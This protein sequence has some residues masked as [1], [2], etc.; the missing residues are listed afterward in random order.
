ML[1]AYYPQRFRMLELSAGNRRLSV[2]VASWGV[3]TIVYL[4]DDWRPMGGGFRAATLRNPW[5]VEGFEPRVYHAAVKVEG[6]W[7]DRKM[8]GTGAVVVRSLR[9]G[10]RKTV[11]DAFVLACLDNG[12]ERIG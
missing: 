6:K 2:P 7:E 8:R 11:G 5:I 1:R 4:Q 12:F 3:G 9:D 10:R